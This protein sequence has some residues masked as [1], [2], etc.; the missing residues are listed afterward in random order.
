MYQQ[1]Y[2]RPPMDVRTERNWAMGA[3]LSTFLGCFGVVAFANIIAPLVIYL[4]KREESSFVADQ[5]KEAL[6]FQISMTI[7]LLLAGLLSMAFIGI[8][9]LVVLALA[10]MILTVV[11]AIK[12]SEG[13]YYRYPLTMQFVK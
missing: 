13:T 9:L 4:M 12:A 5:A 2:Q 3:H 1:S 10:D 7:Y 11:A 6:N 8:P